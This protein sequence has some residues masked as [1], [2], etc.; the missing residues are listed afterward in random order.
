MDTQKKEIETKIDSVYTK[1][2]TQKKEIET[3]MD[4]LSA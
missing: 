2:D 1:M 4:A 3:K